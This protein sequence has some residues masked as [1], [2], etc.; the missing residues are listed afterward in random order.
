MQFAPT[1][2]LT[3][4]IGAIVSTIVGQGGNVLLVR[5]NFTL[6]GPFFGP[7]PSDWCLPFERYCFRPD[8]KLGVG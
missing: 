7:N 2:V 1:F 6:V 4:V 5:A 3:R 8:N